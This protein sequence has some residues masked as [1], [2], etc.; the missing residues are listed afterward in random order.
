[1]NNDQVIIGQS[2]HTKSEP[3]S[4]I[5]NTK[6]YIIAGYT[7]S[8]CPAY[9]LYAGQLFPYCPGSIAANEPNSQQL[10]DCSSPPR[11][12]GEQCNYASFYGHDDQ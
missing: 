1:M 9:S 2:K 3:I 4:I 8:T 7:E 11:G 6:D 10:D 5:K 12:C